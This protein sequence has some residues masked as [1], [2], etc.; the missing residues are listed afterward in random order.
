M[1]YTSFLVYY[2]PET[3]RIAFCFKMIQFSDHISIVPVLLF[4]DKV[5]ALLEALLFDNHS[6]NMSR[7]PLNPCASKASCARQG[8]V[9]FAQR[10]PDLV[11]VSVH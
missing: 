3:V 1:Y 2:T 9:V 4:N 8:G 11:F 6:H 7:M 5:L 10:A